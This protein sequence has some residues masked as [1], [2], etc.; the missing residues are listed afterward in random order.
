MKFLNNAFDR[1]AKKALNQLRILPI[2]FMR[3]SANLARR[4][5]SVTPMAIKVSNTNHPFALG[6]RCSG[7]RTKLRERPS[8]AIKTRAAPVIA[9][10]HPNT[11]RHMYLNECPGCCF[12]AGDRYGFTPYR[13]VK[14]L[15]SP[16]KSE[17]E[18]KCDPANHENCE[19]ES[20]RNY[21]YRRR[22]RLSMN[23]WPR[24]VHRHSNDLAVNL[25]LD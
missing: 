20:G 15:P 16:P 4:V 14:S 8:N 1:F 21:R 11:L 6:L 10:T 17:H 13:A 24:D 2:N 7:Q 18:P 23:L 22:S 5:V 12:N 19:S 25:R 3:T 9:T